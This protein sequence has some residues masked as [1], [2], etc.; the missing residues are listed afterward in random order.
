MRRVGHGADGPTRGTE[1][2]WTHGCR[3]ETPDKRDTSRE[4]GRLLYV[5]VHATH[6]ALANRLVTG[7][8]VEGSGLALEH[9]EKSL[10]GLENLP[11]GVLSLGDRLVVPVVIGGRWVGE[12]GIKG[13]RQR[14]NGR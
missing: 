3:G 11:E 6:V 12:R 4:A 14:G 8:A 1:R 2:P 9:V 5:V 10:G 13:S 7:L